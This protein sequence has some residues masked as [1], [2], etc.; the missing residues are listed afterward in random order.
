[1]SDGDG[2]VVDGVEGVG[3]VVV[4][5]GRPFGLGVGGCD[6]FDL[7]DVHAAPLVAGI[8]GG[9]GV[10]GLVAEEEGSTVFPAESVGA[11]ES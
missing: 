2:D 10:A 3:W 9:V 5:G 6:V 11:D 1:M 4:V 8:D 7:V